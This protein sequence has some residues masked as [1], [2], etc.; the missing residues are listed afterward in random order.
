[1]MCTGDVELQSVAKFCVTLK[2]SPTETI[3]M[4]EST[5]K[6][7]QC[8]PATVYKWHAPFRSGRNS[9]ENDPRSGCG[10]VFSERA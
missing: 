1:M 9:V 10:G 8:S 7:K 5:G 4:I 2:K 3:K 6:Y